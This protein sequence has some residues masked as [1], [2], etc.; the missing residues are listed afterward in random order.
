MKQGQRRSPSTNRPLD[1]P[2]IVGENK[3][4]GITV[5]P[6]SPRLPEGSKPFVTC[7]R[8]TRE[9]FRQ[10]LHPGEAHEILAEVRTPHSVTVHENQHFIF[11][12]PGTVVITRVISVAVPKIKVDEGTG[13]CGTYVELSQAR[14]ARGRFVI[15]LSSNHRYLVGEVG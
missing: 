7:H 1:S 5:E 10:A 11:R 2:I 9:G 6:A 13:Y 4:V 3:K 14:A 15:V 8:P 12:E